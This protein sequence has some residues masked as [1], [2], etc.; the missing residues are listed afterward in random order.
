MSP[1]PCA[2]LAALSAALFCAAAAYAAAV[3]SGGARFA[4][5]GPDTPAPRWIK[6]SGI[7][8]LPS[9]ALASVGVPVY[10]CAHFSGCALYH[11]AGAAFFVLEG[12]WLLLHVCGQRRPDGVAGGLGAELCV[13]AASAASLT[14]C[15]A[16][17]FTCGPGDDDDDNGAPTPWF[18]PLYS[19]VLGVP[20][21]NTWLNDL[22]FYMKCR[23]QATYTPSATNAA[24]L[25][26]FA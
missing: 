13:L 25:L 18:W 23:Y 11:A 21:A 19:A 24:H 20:V 3:A 8:A 7:A 15:F 26:S 16:A 5:L 4:P 14:A 17:G 12:A 22:V 2:V 10:G 6:A 1:P 9:Y